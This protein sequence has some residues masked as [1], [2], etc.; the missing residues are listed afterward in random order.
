MGVLLFS[1]R[2]DMDTWVFEVGWKYH[3]GWKLQ[4]DE[5]KWVRWLGSTS[6]EKFVFG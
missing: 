2:D 3:Q 6:C 5:I 1:R 4:F